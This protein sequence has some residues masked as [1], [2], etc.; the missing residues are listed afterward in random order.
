VD[1]FALTSHNENFAVVVIESLAVGTPVLV[2]EHVGL[3]RY[4]KEKHLGWVTTLAI[5]DVRARLTEAYRARNERQRIRREAMPIIRTDFNEE[6][7]AADY[8]EMYR[9]VGSLPI[10]RA[11]V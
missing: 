4:V 10:K 11:A 8:A 9:N 2:S 3:S 6:K 7:L 1:L 5:N